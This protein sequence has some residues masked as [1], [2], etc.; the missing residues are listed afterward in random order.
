[1]A[2]LIDP[3]KNGGSFHIY[4]RF[5]GRQYMKSLAT[6]RESYAGDLVGAINLTLGKIQN[7]QLVMPPG[8]D[9]WE[10]VKTGGK[11]TAKPTTAEVQT[12]GQLSAWYFSSALPD[13]AKVSGTLRIERVHMDH[14]ERIMGMTRTLTSITSD[15]IQ[16]GV[17]DGKPYGYIR[18]RS[19]ETWGRGKKKKPI[20]PKT[21]SKEIKTLSMIWNRAHGKGKTACGFPVGELKYPRAKAKEPFATWAELAASGKP[22][23]WENLFLS[24]P[25]IEELLAWVKAK[26][27]RCRWFYPVCVFAAHTGARLSEIKRSLKEDFKF[28]TRQVLLREKKRSQS[29]DTTRTVPMSETLAADMQAW[30]AEHPETPMAICSSNG[31]ELSDATFHDEH[32]FFFGGSKYEVLKGYHV[33]RHSYASNL[34]MQPDVE[35]RY[36]DQLMGHQTEEQRRRYQHLRPESKAKAVAMLFR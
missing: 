1:M 26:P 6:N 2:S 11:S 25:E 22:A 35:D 23:P 31:G 36:I 17:K 12:L 9:V 32:E 28:K 10:Y 15:D 33:F 20:A 13:G 3:K 18:R 8:A 16:G 4:F 19:G 7:G 14:V 27:T 24:L 5:G 34:A 21:I 29:T 30:F